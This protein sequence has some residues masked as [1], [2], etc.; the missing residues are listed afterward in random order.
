MSVIAVTNQ[1]GGV[2]KTTATF[3]V[4]AALSRMGKKVL[5][6]DNDPQANLTS[7]C[8]SHLSEDQLTLDEVYLDRRNEKLQLCR[9]IQ[10]SLNLYLLPTD[11][12]LSGVEYYLMSRPEK[13]RILRR[14]LKS[15]E[16][17]FDVILIDNPPSLNLLTLNA[18]VACDWVLVPV[19]AEYFSLEGLSQIRS[20]IEDIH[21]WNPDIGLGG[22]IVNQFNRRRK[23]SG[24]I[25]KMIE[26]EFRDQ[27]FK[28][29]VSNSVKLAESTGA[30]ES[31]FEYS[32]KSQA[33]T[34][35]EDLAQ[36]ISTRLGL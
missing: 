21:N 16:S 2:G 20:T 25:C 7:Y 18:L 12:M 15:L 14:K 32:P 19:Q 34:E 36:E 29:K 24:E 4:G 5:Y 3:N 11:S 1:K 9:L 35:F 10:L 6:V 31:I 33:R 23:L 13:E 26:E 17:E 28:T 27:L 30:G 22:I 8:L